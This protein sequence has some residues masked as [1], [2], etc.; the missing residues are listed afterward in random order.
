MLKIIAMKNRPAVIWVLV[1]LIL[2]HSILPLEHSMTTFKIS[3]LNDVNML[4]LD[5][6]KFTQKESNTKLWLANSSQP[7]PPPNEAEKILSVQRFKN[8]KVYNLNQSSLN[9]SN[10]A[11]T[12]PNL[13][14]NSGSIPILRNQANTTHYSLWTSLRSSADYYLEINPSP[15]STSIV[16][17]YQQAIMQL[18]F[19]YLISGD[20]KY[21]SKAVNWIQTIMDCGILNEWQ[22]NDINRAHLMVAYAF[23]YDWLFNYM[24]P[25]FRRALRER[26]EIEAWDQYY[27]FT[28]NSWFAISYKHNHNWVNSAAL[29][30]L[31]CV[32]EGEIPEAELWL[33]KALDTFYHIEAELF[34]DGSS[35]EGV[36]Y[37]N[38]SLEFLLL[39][40][41][42]LKFRQNKNL[43]SHPFFENAIMYYLYFT[44]PNRHETANFADG[45]RKIWRYPSVMFRLADEF[46][47][48][49]AQ[50]AGIFTS[51]TFGYPDLWYETSGIGNRI[52]DYKH[53]FSGEYSA[54]LLDDDS[55]RL[56]N[57]V[58]EK[59]PIKGISQL[60]LTLY[61]Y[62]ESSQNT[63]VRLLEY[64]QH[65]VPSI[66]TRV[67]KIDPNRWNKIQTH[68]ILKSSTKKIAVEIRPAQRIE[69]TGEIWVDNLVLNFDNSGINILPNPDFEFSYNIGNPLSFLWYNPDIVPKAPTE[70]PT[71]RFF[72]DLG[73][74][75]SKTGWGFNDSMM[76]FKCGSLIGGHDHPDQGTIIY[77][78]A[79]NYVLKDD[80]YTFLKNT[81]N[82]NTITINDQGQIG[83]DKMWSPTGEGGSIIEWQASPW[84]THFKGDVTDSYP[85]NSSLK[86]F[87]REGWFLTTGSNGLLLL[88]DYVKLNTTGDVGWNYHSDGEY[89]PIDQPNIWFVTISGTTYAG[90]CIGVP[91]VNRSLEPT[92]IVPERINGTFNNDHIKTQNGYHVELT[93]TGSEF[94]LIT[95]LFPVLNG[96][97]ISKPKNT[98][99]LV[100]KLFHGAIIEVG[101]S[102]PE[103]IHSSETTVQGD[104]SAY[105]IIVSPEPNN[106]ILSAS[107]FTNVTWDKFH[108]ISSN[109]PIFVMEHI[110]ISNVSLIIQSEQSQS[111]Q[112]LLPLKPSEVRLNGKIIPVNS[113]SHA[114]TS[115]LWNQDNSQLILT[116][117]KGLSKLE[118]DLSKL[119]NFQATALEYGLLIVRGTPLA[120]LNITKEKLEI[121]EAIKQGL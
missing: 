111:I 104:F 1:C 52:Q 62:G 107:N 110:Q 10:R 100:L 41:E 90:V 108:G 24:S 102:R 67:F 103:K 48:R 11:S 56:V 114:L 64:D 22:P 35:H 116:I 71:H 98:D 97:I 30:L 119:V 99:P 33:L 79:G 53:V 18:A 40:M 12:H 28:N 43:Y 39:M 86:T 72:P 87:L 45:Y 3:N 120:V 61:V 42:T 112:V 80:G 26:M 115:A 118:L 84:L 15:T 21:G 51:P 70:L 88:S 54:Y 78:S 95:V 14:F 69:Q 91:L 94:Q 74:G 8:Q 32:L 63:I 73:V 37:W 58:S 55:T 25:E 44:L 96:K 101:S 17:Y 59:I 36:C 49:Y 31:G 16:G 50:W 19:A 83:S 23:G 46:E 117:P 13:L 105:L 76:L 5:L 93:A 75:V 7:Q 82:H 121:G 106:V 68:W 38:Y 29:A 113:L 34:E 81:G 6:Q 85:T 60:N 9:F 89:L 47:N 4:I 20:E 92:I 77:Y 66:T 65:N 57:L 2:T 109:L 27:H